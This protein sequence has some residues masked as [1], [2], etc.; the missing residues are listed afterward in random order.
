LVTWCFNFA[1]GP[2][3]GFRCEAG[4]EFSELVFGVK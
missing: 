1:F 4:Q 3:D 2:I